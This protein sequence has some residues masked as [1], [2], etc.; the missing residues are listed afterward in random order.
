MGDEHVGDPFFEASGSKTEGP[1]ECLCDYAG[2]GRRL[3]NKCRLRRLCS[4]YGL[5]KMTELSCLPLIA[6]NGE[7]SRKTVPKEGV[8]AS[9]KAAMEGKDREP[10]HSRARGFY[11]PPPGRT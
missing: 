9:E 1:I 2:K 8:R 7:Q 6:A 3:R 10:L 11:F 4:T 5:A